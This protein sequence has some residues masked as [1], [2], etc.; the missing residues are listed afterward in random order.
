MTANPFVRVKVSFRAKIFA[1]FALFII[2]ISSAFT[3]FLI[4]HEIRSNT[5]RLI[6]EGK[7]LSGLLAYDARLAV[8]A[9]NKLMMKE[10]VA[11]ISPHE[12]VLAVD[13]YA[14]DGKLLLEEVKSD[15]KRFSVNEHPLS[16]DVLKL[17]TSD[18]ETSK[19]L[20]RQ[21][22]DKIEFYAPVSAIVAPKNEESL[23]LNENPHQVS[24]RAIGLVRIALDKG[25]L[26]RQVSKLIATSIILGCLFL[27]L[28]SALAFLVLKGI[29]TPLNRLMD[30]VLSLGRGEL[31]KR[32]SVETKDE[33]G[34]VAL[35]FNNM[36]DSLERREQEKQRLEEQLRLAQKLEAKEEWERTFDTVPDLIAILD[37]DYRIIRVNR[38]MANQLAQTKEAVVGR[39]CSDFFQ[40]AKIL[41]DQHSHFTDNDSYAAEIYEE[42]LNSHYWVTITPLRKPD[43]SN[44]GSVYIARDITQRKMAEEESKAIQAKLVQANKMTSIGLLVSGLA[45]DI[46]NPNG[47]ILLAAHLLAK[48]WKDI[49]P[50]LDKFHVDEGDFSIAGHD[51]SQIRETLS[52]HISGIIENSRRIEGIINN[53]KDYVRIGKANLAI[54]TDI[55]NVVTVSVAILKSHI[56]RHTEH[57]ELDLD[58]D[59]PPIKGNPQQLEQVVVNLI[60]NALQA[61]PDKNRG[62]K[63]TTTT[64]HSE[65]VV[66]IRVHD[67][68]CGMTKEVL[69]R[70]CEPFFST[71]IDSGGT[72]LGLAIAHSIIKEHKGTLDFISEVGIGT[73]AIV[74]L[75]YIPVGHNTWKE[76]L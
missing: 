28:G 26:N 55:N 16:A 8:Y 56:S 66:I 58:D 13:I 50:I 67:A 24:H 33:I 18:S 74:K 25:E 31:S 76:L 1:V 29:I 72:G 65:E 44:S 12:H 42:I 38:A 48:S 43:G 47:S 4:R 9:E 22:K 64:D 14:I 10:A 75:P 32:V 63:V 27:I 71:K 57:F 45:H 2:S 52:H 54:A 23:Y 59:L 21:E 3:Y 15:G 39:H 70:I 20:V 49:V 51:Y 68:G 40:G 46:N 73:T 17:V 5:D 41:A 62:V 6:I 36:A 30:G 7:L 34:M 53:L 19:P 60:L 37:W 61:L 11:G 35:A 69:I